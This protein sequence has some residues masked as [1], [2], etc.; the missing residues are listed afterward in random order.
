[1]EEVVCLFYV[2]SLFCEE[3]VCAMYINMGWKGLSWGGGTSLR[4]QPSQMKTALV[5]CVVHTT[6]ASRYSILL[7]S[8]SLGVSIVNP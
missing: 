8:R 1:M 5:G 2:C 7:V 6:L 4:M 3:L